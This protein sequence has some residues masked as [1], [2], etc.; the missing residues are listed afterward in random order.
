MNDNQHEDEAHNSISSLFFGDSSAE[1][2]VDTSNTSD[3]VKEN[4][5]SS[6]KQELEEMLSGIKEKFNSLD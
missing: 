6:R 4:A 1:M 3:N 5:I 2:D